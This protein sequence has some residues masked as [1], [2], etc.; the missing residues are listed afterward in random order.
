MLL[1]FDQVKLLTN[2]NLPTQ[3][4]CTTPIIY[5]SAI[6][7]PSVMPTV[8]HRMQAQHIIG[9]KEMVD[10][11]DW[12]VYH[13]SAKADTGAKS[14]AIDVA[15]IAELGQNRIRFE[16]ILD[17]RERARTQ[18]VETAWISKVKVRSSNGQTHERYRVET[19][20]ALG[21]W[22]R[23][24]EFTLVCRKRMIHRV[25][26]GRTFLAKNFSVCSTSRYLVTKQSRS[27]R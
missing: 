27:P 17:R 19:T 5:V 10:L 6:R 3:P 11:P 4:S 13:L 24:T 18:T 21:T 20:V 25:L 16:V 23:K 9:W 2:E 22:R 15:N 8:H 26:L 12:G 14:S 7:K 1:S